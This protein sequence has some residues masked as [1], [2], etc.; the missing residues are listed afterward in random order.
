[1]LEA[2]WQQCEAKI[3]Q[4]RIVAAEDTVKLHHE[5]DKMQQ[6]HQRYEPI[7]DALEQQISELEQQ[8]QQQQQQQN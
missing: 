7:I 1:M 3:A 8:I 5:M 2:Q 6:L 4:L